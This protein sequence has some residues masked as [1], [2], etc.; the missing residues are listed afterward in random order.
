MTQF[1]FDPVTNSELMCQ[2][3]GAAVRADR[4]N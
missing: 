2:E 1:E 4:P 3:A